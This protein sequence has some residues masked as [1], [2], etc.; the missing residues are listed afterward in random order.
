[1]FSCL[2]YT[3]ISRGPLLRLFGAGEEGEGAGL[4]QQLLVEDAAEGEHGEAGV[5]DLLELPQHRQVNTQ[6]GQKKAL[7]LKVVRARARRRR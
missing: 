6:I 3:I 7:R 5:L 2:F 1:M 4:G